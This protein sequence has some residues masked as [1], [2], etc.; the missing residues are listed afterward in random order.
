MISR[1]GLPTSRGMRLATAASECVS[2]CYLA[3][4]TLL[5]N[6]ISMPHDHTPVTRNKTVTYKE[7]TSGRVLRRPPHRRA[8]RCTMAIRGA[9]A[10]G[11]RVD[12]D[13]LTARTVEALRYR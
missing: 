4:M 2:P 9:R 6:C 8:A 10:C 12:S 11:A 5:N 7:S 13:P 1:R 3:S